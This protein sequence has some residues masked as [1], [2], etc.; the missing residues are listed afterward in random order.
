MTFHL[1]TV[2]SLMPMI[3]PDELNSF[4]VMFFGLFNNEV[5]QKW[6]PNGPAQTDVFKGTTT[7]PVICNVE[8]I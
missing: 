3:Y 4:I 2:L 6:A 7:I 1:S 5:S 8:P